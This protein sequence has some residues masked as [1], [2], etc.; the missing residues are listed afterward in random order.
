MGF[1]SNKGLISSRSQGSKWHKGPQLN[2]WGS[3]LN[4]KFK[5]IERQGL[6]NE[7]AV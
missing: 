7:T 2:S 4:E 6:L 5:P 1:K 3:H